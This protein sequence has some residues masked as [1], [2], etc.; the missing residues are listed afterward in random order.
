VVVVVD[1]GTS[2]KHWFGRKEGGSLRVGRNEG[3]AWVR[4]AKRARG[5]TEAGS[6]DGKRASTVVKGRSRFLEVPV[7]AR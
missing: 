5:T 1:D 6:E 2:T 4:R 7:H 3:E